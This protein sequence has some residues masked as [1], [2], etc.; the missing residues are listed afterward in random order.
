MASKRSLQTIKKHPEKQGIV[1]ESRPIFDIGAKVIF[2]HTTAFM[3]QT[4]V[5]TFII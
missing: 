2:K 3:Q 4:P 1:I 5:F